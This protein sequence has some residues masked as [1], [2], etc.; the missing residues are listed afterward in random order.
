MNIVSKD[1]ERQQLPVQVFQE[2]DRLDENQ[3][4]NDLKR[5]EFLNELVYDAVIE[6]RKVTSLSITG[7]RE[8]GR[9]RGKYKIT[10]LRVDDDRD[11]FRCMMQMHD[12]IQQIDVVGAAT[13]EKSK[14]FAYTLCI[15]KAERNCLRKLLPE[16]LIA[17][18]IKEFLERKKPRAVTSKPVPAKQT[19][20]PNPTESPAS[21]PQERETS[22]TIP[23]PKSPTQ[24]I[25]SPTSS[26]SEKTQAAPSEGQTKGAETSR[27]TPHWKIPTEAD[28]LSP[29]QIKK[30]VRQ[31]PLGQGLTLYGMINQF[32]DQLAIVSEKP[33]DPNSPPI[34]WFLHGTA[35]RAGVIEPLCEKHHLKWENLL[36]ENGL[37]KAIIIYGGILEKKQV[38]ELV[39]G[40]TWA[41]KAA[42]EPPRLDRTHVGS[43]LR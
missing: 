9:R 17:E 24:S 14:P 36:D 11:Q 23:Q 7:V 13:C 15:N 28:Q 2:L 29:D 19:E 42:T 5:E 20:F 16:K 1:T 40:A 38:D 3:S 22:G 41:F 31:R 21:K 25:N 39:Q 12:D 4:L 10:D 33:V 34:W 37:L 18:M 6:G 27:T 35:T 26:V 32:E 43:P 8:A 30:G